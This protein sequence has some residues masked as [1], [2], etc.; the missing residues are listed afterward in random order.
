[1]GWGRG[2]GERQKRVCEGLGG[3]APGLPAAASLPPL[4]GTGVADRLAHQDL[5]CRED[6]WYPLEPC[7]ETYPDRGQCHLQFQFIHKRVGLGPGP[8]ASQGPSWA[9]R[10][11]PATGRSAHG[12]PDPPAESHRCQPLPAQLH[13]APPPAAA[14]R[15]PRGHPA[16]GTARP[17]A[18]GRA[19]PRADH[20]L[21]PL[22]PPS[23]AGSTSWDGSLSAQAAT[24]LF[25]HATQKD[26]SDFHQS[27][28]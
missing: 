6:H 1:M 22:R 19:G 5:R 18:R 4:T 13:G 28:A 23:Q 3:G 2:P 20:P 11:T 27:M 15:V 8:G 12:R 16:P 21:T 26:L 17:P 25:L 14:A 7:T 24:I 9:G 10:A